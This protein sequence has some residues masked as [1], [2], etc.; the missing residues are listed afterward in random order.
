MAMLESLCLSL[1]IMPL[2]DGN[3]TAQQ[4]FD[5]A[6]TADPICGLDTSLWMTVLAAGLN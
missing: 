3:G 4:G 1:V 2:Q 6:H 5:V